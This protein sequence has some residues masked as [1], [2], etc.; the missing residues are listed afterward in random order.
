MNNIDDMPAKCKACHYWE[1]CEYPYICQDVEPKPAENG[2]INAEIAENLQN[3]PT[4]GDLI[5]R[6]AAIDALNEQIEQCNKALGS[7]GISPKDEYAI[8][9]ERASLKAYKKQLENL[10]PVQPDEKFEK[11]RFEYVNACQIVNCHTPDITWRDKQNAY[12]IIKVLQPIF[13]DT[14][15]AKVEGGETE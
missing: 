1:A 7:F 4:N 11:C 10:P 5:S 2:N 13:G 3:R 9:V 12:A 8:K 15:F 6:Q 14:P